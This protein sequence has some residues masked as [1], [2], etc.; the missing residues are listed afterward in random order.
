VLVLGVALL[1]CT[2]VGYGVA[3]QAIR[4]IQEITGTARRISPANLSERLSLHGLPGEML[5]LAD[6]FNQ[7]LE[8]LE[9]SFGRLSRFSADIAHELRTPVHSLRGGVEVA[10]SKPRSPE[11]YREVLGSSLEECARLAHLIDRLLFLARAEHPETQIKREPCDVGLELATVSEFYGLSASDAGVRLAV[12]IDRKIQ[13]DLDRPLFQRAVGNLVANSLAH[14]PR[15]GT[16]TLTATGDGLATKVDVTDTGC[17]IPTN[18]LANVCD[19]FYR[20]DNTRSSRNGNVGLGL[21]IVRSIMELHG[22][23][24]EIASQVGQGTR[25]SLVFPRN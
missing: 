19:R 25:V 6:T 16:V 14:T 24:V 15:G 18:H 8:R 22:G 17:G 11:E 9:Q 23:T 13:A 2:A 10:L 3:R 5:T 7:M 20:A 12:A 4:P 1:I 21:A